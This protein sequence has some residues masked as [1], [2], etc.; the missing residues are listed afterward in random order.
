MTRS[1]APR[2]AFLLFVFL[3]AP[4]V[5]HGQTNVESN[6]NCDAYASCSLRVQHGLLNTRIVRGAES[7]HLARIG[8]GT[9]PLEELFARTDASAISFDQFSAD[10]ARS[11]WLAVLGGIGFVG[12]M[13]ARARGN[14]DWAA[15]LSI[16]GTVFEVGAAIF[17]R[18]AAEH[19]S[20]AI[21][22]YN[23]SLSR[24]DAR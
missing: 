2:I 3:G 8:L 15:G 11:S 10:H 18:K 24:P 14:E 19:L 4:T 13:I 12:G 20:Q 23:E 1:N 6:L 9:P 5:T 21:W 7:T 22:W 16:G 17:T